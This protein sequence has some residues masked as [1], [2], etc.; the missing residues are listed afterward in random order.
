MACSPWLVG[1]WSLIQGRVLFCNGDAADVGIDV[2]WEVIRL[3]GVVH[4]EGMEIVCCVFFLW[5]VDLMMGGS[6]Q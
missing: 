1:A 3:L 2:G 6:D 4:C 5:A